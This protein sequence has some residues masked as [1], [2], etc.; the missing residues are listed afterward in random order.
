MMRER[1][2]QEERAALVAAAG[3]NL[4]VTGTLF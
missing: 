1:A 4:A 3:P 2:Q